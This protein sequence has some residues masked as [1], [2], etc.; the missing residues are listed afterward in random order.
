VKG[1]DMELINLNVSEYGIGLTSYFG[2]VY[3]FWRTIALVAGI[4]IVLR[5]AK[6]I[7]KNARYKARRFG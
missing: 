3:V 4:V 2:D 7:R 6:V 5:I 1:T